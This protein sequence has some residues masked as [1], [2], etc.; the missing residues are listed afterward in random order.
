MTVLRSVFPF[1][2][3][4]TVVQIHDASWRFI[5]E[6][7]EANA[8]ET[9]SVVPKGVSLQVPRVR[10]ARSPRIVHVQHLD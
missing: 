7:V 8:P 2:H 1:S 4:A 6:A 3:E 5:A 9:G 10:L